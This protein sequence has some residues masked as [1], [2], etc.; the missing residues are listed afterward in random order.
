MK[1]ANLKIGTRLGA[2]FALV[3]VLLLVVTLLGISHM[4]GIKGKLDEITSVNNFESKQA[5]IMRMTVYDRMLAL[6]NL[7][8]LSDPAEMAPEVER[9]RKQA[10]VYK[11]AEQELA[12]IFNSNAATTA[13]EKAML[14]R[15]REAEAAILPVMAKAAELGLANKAEEAT[16][17]LIQ[18]VRPLQKKWI[19]ELNDLVAF[20][21][22]LTDQAVTAAGQQYDAART[23]MFAIS[24]LALVAGSVIAWAITVS[25]TRPLRD[26]VA[27]ART[28]AAGDLTSRIEVTSTDEAGELLQSLK[29]MNDGLVRI[30]GEV[31]RGTDT[32]SSATLQISGGNLELSSRTEQQASSLEETASSLEELTS[33]VQQNADNAY[34]ANQ[35]AACASEVATKGGRG[36]GASGA[37]HGGHQRIGAQ[38]RRHHQRHRRHRVPDQYPC[39]ERSGGSSA[40][41]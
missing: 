19:G 4:A 36:G 5:T 27:V 24:A 34:Q 11:D 17:T 21:E 22:K 23:R 18:E 26:A 6:R 32:I 7:A 35:L 12:R 8:L 10:D 25:I 1:I 9:I 13:E 40:R 38:D 39:V 2:G 28:V 30:V 33:T 20:E 41:R 14:A 3:L 37:N 15:V 29:D 16:R 31:R